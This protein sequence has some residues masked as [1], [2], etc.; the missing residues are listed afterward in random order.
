VPHPCNS[1]RAWPCA[2]HSLWRVRCPFLDR[3]HLVN[4]G[5]CE[6]LAMSPNTVPTIRMKVFF[7]HLFQSCNNRPLALPVTAPSWTCGHSVPNRLPLPGTVLWR[8]F[9][10]GLDRHGC[11]RVASNH[12]HHHHYHHLMCV[13]DT[14][15]DL[16]TRQQHQHVHRQHHHT[17]RA[18]AAVRPRV[19]RRAP[20]P[21]RIV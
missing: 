14:L 20:I 21:S 10:T 1:S 17:T 4:A 11:C 8:C 19:E 6:A 5:S 2:T 16:T 12:H 3:A 9:F 18:A 13:G 7:A 15:S